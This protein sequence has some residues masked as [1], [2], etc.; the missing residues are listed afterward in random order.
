M[1]ADEAG[2]LEAKLKDPGASQRGNGQLFIGL[3]TAN[4]CSSEIW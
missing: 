2:W 4:S 3:K 1:F